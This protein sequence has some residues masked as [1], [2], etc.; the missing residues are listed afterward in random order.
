MIQEQV[1]KEI[2]RLRTSVLFWFR[3][4]LCTETRRHSPQ[5]SFI[6]GRRGVFA[7]WTRDRENYRLT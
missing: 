7:F 4:N 5:R 3:S 1:K 2:L 6:E